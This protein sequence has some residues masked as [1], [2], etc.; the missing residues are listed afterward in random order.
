MPRPSQIAHQ[1]SLRQSSAQPERGVSTS[2][3][4]N[5]VSLII[6]PL[7]ARDRRSSR[8]AGRNPV[9]QFCLRAGDH[10][11]ERLPTD[12]VA[13][14]HRLHQ[15][16]GQHLAER[17]LDTRNPPGLTFVD[18]ARDVRQ[19]ELAIHGFGPLETRD[20]R[21]A[22]RGSGAATTGKA[23]GERVGRKMSRTHG[24]LLGLGDGAHG[25]LRGALAVGDAAQAA[26]QIPR[27]SNL[28]I[29][30]VK[31]TLITQFIESRYLLN[32]IYVVKKAFSSSAVSSGA[33]SGT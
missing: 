3:L 19:R 22:R 10:P 24:L 5:S 30:A 18:G 33:S 20:V 21:K 8:E 2:S 31:R 27:G 29:A 11:P 9:D 26:L 28:T 23:R 17:R 32:S 16:I 12:A 1:S 15:W 6:F 14:H 7:V 25:S 13:A 4:L